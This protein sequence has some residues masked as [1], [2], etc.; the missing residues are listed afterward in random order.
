MRLAATV[1]YAA[2]LA[3]LPAAVHAQDRSQ[4]SAPSAA[5]VPAPKADAGP[6]PK[7]DA[8]PAPGAAPKHG[9][10]AKPP[11]RAAS[12]LAR[13]LLTQE[14]WDRLLDGYAKSLSSQLTQSLT[15]GGEKVP[16]DLDAKVRSE[17]GRK[18]PYQQTVDAQAEALAKQLTPDELSKVAS[19]YSSPLG[20]K[21]LDRLPEAQT[22]A[23]QQL[24]ARLATAVPEIV[25]Q[26]A[27]KALAPGGSGTG[28][29]AQPAPG[30]DGS[31]PPG[32]AQQRP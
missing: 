32:G 28:S 15:A 21:V 3:V 31:P 5:P 1:T 2:A 7:A 27:P 24:Q 22:A 12:D 11:P 6:A 10:A 9:A 17:L 23:A 18:L 14:Q 20:R 29:G 26:L 30:Q 19:F 4:A 13:A 16:D 25:Q 8:P